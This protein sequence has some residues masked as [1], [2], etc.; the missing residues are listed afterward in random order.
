MLKGQYNHQVMVGIV[1]NQKEML[2]KSTSS[3]HHDQQ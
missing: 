3:Q 1:A 2:H